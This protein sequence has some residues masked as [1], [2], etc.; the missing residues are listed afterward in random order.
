M[1]F[2]LLIQVCALF[3]FTAPK[4][5]ACRAAFSRRRGP[6]W[7]AVAQGRLEYF[8]QISIAAA[9]DNAQSNPLDLSGIRI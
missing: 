2:L 7:G 5:T 4:A 8:S 1:S 6:L 3:D 9:R